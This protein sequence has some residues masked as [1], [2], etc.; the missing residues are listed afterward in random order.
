MMKAILAVSEKF[1][2][3]SMAEKLFMM[4]HSNTLRITGGRLMGQELLG[5]ECSPAPMK[6]GTTEAAFQNEGNTKADKHRSI[7]WQESMTVQDNTSSI[8]SQGFHQD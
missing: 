8:Q 3:L 6:T 5:S 2:V 1:I 4:K 7:A